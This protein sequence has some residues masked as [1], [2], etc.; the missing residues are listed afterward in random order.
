MLKNKFKALMGCLL[1]NAAM[2]TAQTLSLDEI[3]IKIRTNNPQLKMYDS[4][5]QSMDEAVKGSKSWMPPQ[6]STG[7]FM[8]P[9]NTD[10][11]KADDMNPGMGN[12]ML[13]VEQM[14]PN[15]S[16]QKANQSLMQAMSSV[17]K[18]NK[19]YSINQLIAAAKTNYYQ[20]IILEKKH[21]VATNNLLLLSYMIKSMEIRYAYNMDKLPAYYKTKSQYG[22]LESMLV[23]LENG[24]SQKQIALN[25]L[26]ARDK[27]TSFGIDSIYQISDFDMVKA[28][29]A[30]LAQS[31]SDLRAIEKTMEINE[32]RIEAE[33]SNL[34]PEFGLKYDH[35]FAFGDNPQQFNLMMMVNIPFAPWASK[36][37][38]SNQHSYKIKNEGLQW[39]KQMIMNETMGMLYA[40][41]TEFR[42]IKKQ[43][44]IANK[45]IIPALKK[46]YDTALLAWQNNTGDLSAVQEAWEALNMAQLDALDKLEA[47]L[48]TQ[49]EIEKQLEIY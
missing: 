4:E 37:N 10:M 43:Y 24:I 17:E 47:I 42:N 3:L 11:W 36:M 34:L 8:T 13:G 46:N 20:W 35:M 7:F 26:M 27:Q 14:I 21:R 48:I 30:I 12:Y 23:M 41:H 2:M 29:T 31:R 6:V 9:Y 49:V 45:S 28:D 33:R 19:N 5:I 38:K 1:L 22:S 39:Q 32:L 16:R 44:D 40:M 18:E 25:S 15:P